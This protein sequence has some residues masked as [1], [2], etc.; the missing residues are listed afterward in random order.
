[1][2]KNENIQQMLSQIEVYRSFIAKEI[3]DTQF[4]NKPMELYEPVRYILDLGG[5]RMRPIL[6]MMACEMFSGEF[7]DAKTL[8]WV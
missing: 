1:M 6:S 2:K 8:R 5:K 7:R 4:P 3:A